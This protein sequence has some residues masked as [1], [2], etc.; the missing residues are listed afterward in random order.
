MIPAVLLPPPLRAQAAPSV[1]LRVAIV[2][3]GDSPRAKAITANL[4]DCGMRVQRLAPA[5]CQPSAF[6][7]ADVVVVDWPKELEVTALQIGGFLR[8]HRPTLFLGSSGERFAK[9]WLLPSAQLMAQMAVSERGPAMQLLEFGKD[10]AMTVWRQG[11]LFYLPRDLSEQLTL[12]TL[13]PIAAC[14]RRAALFVV[15]RPVL[16]F[17][18]PDDIERRDLVVKLADELQVAI[19]D[20]AALQKLPARIRTKD[21]RPARKLLA[22]CLEGGPGESQ[23]LNNWKSWLRPRAASLH[24]DPLSK[25]WRSDQLAHWRKVASKDLRGDDRADGG[26]RDAEA[27]AIASKTVQYHG[28]HALD[29][30]ATFSC[31]YGQLHFL[32]DRQRGYFRVENH[33]QV[34][35]RAT[36]WQASAMDSFTDQQLVWGNGAGRGPRIASRGMYRDLIERTFLP[37]MLLDPGMGLR[38]LAEESTKEEAVLAVKLVGRGLELQSEFA[39]TIARQTGA[40]LCF[41]ER[42]GSRLSTV[43]T[44][45]ETTACGPLKLPTHWRA[46]TLRRTRDHQLQDVRWNPKLPVG[47]ESATGH[48][49][50]PRDG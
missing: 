9:A 15:D 36:P 38:Y 28:G 25:I 41:E 37:L 5:D 47:I 39:L 33:N 2:A 14:V 34:Y 21:E 30:L 24:W 44:L 4:R 46:K 22:S 19:G 20:M 32:W 8:W 27:L 48:L 45:V 10:D 18:D 40:L 12:H 16:R 23:T 31:W 11:N 26:V 1:G 3:T 7:N 17:S 49:T 29:D 35:A 42:N 43:F 13:A 6:W 50:A